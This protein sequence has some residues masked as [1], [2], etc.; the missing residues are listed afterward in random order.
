V[1]LGLLLFASMTMSLFG[2]S[3]AEVSGK[4]QPAAETHR[5]DV[6]PAAAKPEPKADAAVAPPPQSKSETLHFNVNWPSGLSLGEGEMSAILNSDGW[7]FSYHLDAGVPGFSINES[8][9]SRA[10]ADFCSLELV[11]EGNR[12]KRHLQETTTFDSSGLTATRTTANGGGKTETRTSACAKDALTFIQFA[13]RELAAGRLPAAQPV[14][15]G[16]GYQTRVQYT[17]TQ[18]IKVDNDTV[19]VDRLNAIIKGPATELTV[20]LFFARDAARTP[21]LV[22][23][24]VAMGKFSVEFGKP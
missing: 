5:I 17:G 14:F 4:S 21:V 20:E 19:E 13:R 10:S 18:R 15:Y 8:A 9:H 11:K 12:G 6:K 16:A 2:A 1:K 24:P 23:I 22:Q 7:S 3:P